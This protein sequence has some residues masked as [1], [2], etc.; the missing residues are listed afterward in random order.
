MNILDS[1]ESGRVLQTE[2]LRLNEEKCFVYVHIDFCDSSMI[3]PYLV[4]FFYSNCFCHGL[5]LSK[6]FLFR[7]SPIH[8]E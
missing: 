1:E 5:L 7:H 2:D 6:S 8:V 3:I 4:F